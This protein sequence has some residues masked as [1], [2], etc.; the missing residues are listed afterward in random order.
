MPKLI[1]L[2]ITQAAIGF[3][4]AGVFVV[5]MLVFNFANLGHLVRNSDM[6]VLAVF[7]LWAFNGIVFGAVQFAIAV[8]GMAD[9]DDDDQDGGHRAYMP[10]P[11][12]VRR[13]RR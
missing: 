12:L 5:L 13:D 4:L 8:M 3:A 9:D 2:F 11:I 1:R 6:G 7:L 10:I